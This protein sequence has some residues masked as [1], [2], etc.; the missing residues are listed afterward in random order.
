MPESTVAADLH[1]AAD[2]ALN[3]SAEVA[4]DLVLAVQNLAQ[5]S[6]LTF[7]QLTHFACWVD[8]GPLDHLVNIVLS[9]AIEQRKS[10]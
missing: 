9:D 7:A 5:L 4:F 6:N 8:T 3:L 2:I 10:I 1:Q